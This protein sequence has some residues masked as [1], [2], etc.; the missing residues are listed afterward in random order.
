MDRKFTVYM[1]IFPNKKK[2]I[3][4]TC[5]TVEKRWR[6]GD[7]YGEDQPLMR[8]A[9]KKYGWENIEH[10]ILFADLTKDQACTKEKE[11]IKKYKTFNDNYGYNMTTGGDGCLKYETEEAKEEAHQ[12]RLK[13][14]RQY[15]N[16]NKKECTER[17]RKYRENNPE[18]IKD[19]QKRHYQ[20]NKE[21]IL[22]Y[23]KE[24]YQKNK[25][26]I[27]KKSKQ[28]VEKNKEKTKEYQKNYRETHKQELKEYFKERYKKK[29]KK[30]GES[31]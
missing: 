12:K 27:N 1:H 29:K 20:Q 9:I 22:K 26:E 19:G 8:N 10:K 30:D 23:H 7:G 4:I 14:V 17:N 16:K 3:G 24:Y 25:E 2:Y 13:K 15:Y 6:G 5:Q 11:L 28:Y 21:K 18:K 31:K